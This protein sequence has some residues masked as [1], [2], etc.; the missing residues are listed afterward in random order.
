MCAYVFI[1]RSRVIIFSCVFFLLL[2]FS[3]HEN[4]LNESVNEK[5]GKKTQTHQRKLFIFI[6]IYN[7][8]DL[9]RANVKR[10][11]NNIWSIAWLGETFH[12]KQSNRICAW[13]N[14][15]KISNPNKLQHTIYTWFSKGST[16][17]LTGFYYFYIGI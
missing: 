1:L 13:M 8:N 12:L 16:F 17:N 9:C 4:G 15:I 10:F 14:A 3:K 2:L 7:F 6:C 5:R 11:R